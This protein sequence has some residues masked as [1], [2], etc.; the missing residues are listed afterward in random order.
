MKKSEDGVMIGLLVCV[1]VRVMV[2][3][4]RLEEEKK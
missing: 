4:G 3:G 1:V 2:M